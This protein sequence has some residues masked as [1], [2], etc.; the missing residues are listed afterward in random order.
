MRRPEPSGI[1]PHREPKVPRWGEYVRSQ[2]VCHKGPWEERGSLG[3]PERSGP[4]L[5]IGP[6]GATS[7]GSEGLDKAVLQQYCQVVGHLLWGG[8]EADRGN[9]RP[10]NSRP[11]SHREHHIHSGIKTWQDKSGNP[12]NTLVA[13]LPEV[14]SKK[15]E[16]EGGRQDQQDVWLAPFRQLAITR[17]G[18]RGI[19]RKAKDKDH[20]TKNRGHGR[21]VHCQAQ[22]AP[23]GTPEASSVREEFD[24]HSRRDGQ[25]GAARTDPR[26]ISRH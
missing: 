24:N 4:R 16:Q 6:T 20:T 12:Y 19:T 15:G 1:V 18:D 8:A 3:A 2:P 7:R 11:K 25:S 21:I 14:M 5:S 13:R 17:T 26:R 23:I 22:R 9:R 10:G